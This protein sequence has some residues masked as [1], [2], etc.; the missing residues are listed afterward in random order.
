M[1]EQEIGCLFDELELEAPRDFIVLGRFTVRLEKSRL[2]DISRKAKTNNRKIEH[3][4]KM[5][6]TLLR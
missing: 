3:T 4:F 2:I 5:F 6:K 1:T